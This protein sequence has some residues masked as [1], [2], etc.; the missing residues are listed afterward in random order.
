MLGTD[1]ARRGASRGFGPFTG[2]QLT[3]IIVAGMV[4]MVLAPVGPLSAMQAFPR[5]ETTAATSLTLASGKSES[6]IFSA[7][8]G[9]DP[10]GTGWVSQG[11]T[12]AQPLAKA[13]PDS[14]IVSAVKSAPNC[15]GVGHAARGY[16][17]LY[18]MVYGDVG[19]GYGFSSS[20]PVGKLGVM[21]YWTATGPAPHVSGA[22]TVTAP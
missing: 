5:A 13:I 21:L 22:Y 3:T 11:I 6:G 2:R 18:D 8:G 16:L 17:C 7:A 14:H 1:K 12:Y 19:L 9:D 20:V 4:A 10:S 15:A